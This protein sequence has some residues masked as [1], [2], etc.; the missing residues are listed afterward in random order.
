MEHIEKVI[1][2]V[3]YKEYVD[4]RANHD[5]LDTY[6]FCKRN[7]MHYEGDYISDMD[8]SLSGIPVSESVIKKDK[9]TAQTWWDI[10]HLAFEKP[11]RI[12]SFG[13]FDLNEFNKL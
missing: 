12:V 3:V 5:M 2:D 8:M 7:A 1:M 6:A 4:Y 13:N 11:R 10:I 9:Y